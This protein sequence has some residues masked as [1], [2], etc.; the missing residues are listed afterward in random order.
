MSKFDYNTAFSRN[1]GWVNQY[2]QDLLKDKVI[3]IPG[4]GGVGGHHF[5]SLLRVGFSKFKISD[6]DQFDVHNF[7]RQVGAS[8]NTLNREKSEV[9]SNIAKSINPECEIEVF[10]K[11]ITDNNYKFFLENVDIIVDGLDIFQMDIRIKLYE[12]AH[13]LNIPVITAAPLGMGTSLLAFNPKGTSFNQYFNLDSNLSTN[14]KMIRFL[15]GV[16]PKVMHLK[17]LKYKEFINIGEGKVPSLHMGCLSA[18]SAL[19]SVCTKIALNRGEVIWAPRGFQV[20]FYRNK[21]KFFWRPFGNKNPLQKLLIYFI[22][23]KFK[24]QGL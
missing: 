1:L 6:F 16:A 12:H 13:R 15:A 19:S 20:D 22:K 23:R 3:A 21:M 4:L 5:H 7:N 24:N 14:E 11:G 9:M 18:T 17:Y 8:M 2:E 10:E